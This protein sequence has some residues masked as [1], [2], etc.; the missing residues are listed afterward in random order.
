MWEFAIYSQLITVTRDNIETSSI[1]FS[2]IKKLM[3][4]KSYCETVL[5]IHGI[6]KFW[7]IKNLMIEGKITVFKSVAISKLV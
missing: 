5:N 2:Y 6:L 3:D 4:Q 7:W 1:Y